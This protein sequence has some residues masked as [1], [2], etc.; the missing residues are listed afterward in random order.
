[1]KKFISITMALSILVAYPTTSVLA[2]PNSNDMSM[3][4]NSDTDEDD[5][6][7]WGLLGLLGL[8]GLAGLKKKE[9]TSTYTTSGT[10]QNR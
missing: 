4:E 3:N 1:M 8:L 9:H 6:G 2:Q 7:R 10:P 5:N